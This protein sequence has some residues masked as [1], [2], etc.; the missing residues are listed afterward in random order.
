MSDPAELRYTATHEW[1][2]VQGKKIIV[3]LS[4]HALAE[5]SDVIKVELPEPDEHHY[6]PGDDVGVI[7][8]VE[9]SVDLHAPVAGTIVAANTAA[10]SR[11]DVITDDPYGEG[12][13]IE[14]KPDS[15]ADLRNLMNIDEYEDSLPQEE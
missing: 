13:L 6:A 7:E 11:P 8:S 14:M 4:E 10:F 5:I 12:W 9:A 1:V 15:M 2:R 3:G